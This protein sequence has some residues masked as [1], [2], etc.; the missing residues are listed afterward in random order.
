MK[1]LISILIT[2]MMTSCI[3]FATA[4]LV[5]AQSNPDRVVDGAG[6]L[7]QAEHDWLEE[8]IA[9][10][11][12]ANQF[13]IVIVTCY[14]NMSE[15]QLMQFA[16][17]YYDYKGYGYGDNLDGCILVVDMGSRTTWISTSGYGIDVLTDYGIS[18]M[19]DRICDYLADEDYYSAFDMCYF[20]RVQE[21]Y[22]MAEAGEPYDVPGPKVGE[23][24]F[25][26]TIL[27]IG[28]FPGLIIAAIMTRVQKSKHKT[29]RRKTEAQSYVVPGSLTLTRRHDRFMYSHVSRTE[30]P[31]DNDGG[32]RGGSTTHRSSSGRVHGG[33]GGHF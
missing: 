4:G 20:E 11:C 26:A 10:W 25:Y 7:S 5:C 12:E 31:K 28:F 30:K 2:L 16:D 14:N 6:I 1:R 32:G 24:G 13:D 33:G 21:L 15:E 18:K 23:A 9:E 29:I 8:D 3:V 19:T 27:G 22:E 17:D